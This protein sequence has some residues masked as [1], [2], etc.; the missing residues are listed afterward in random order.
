MSLR[1]RALLAWPLLAAA[2]GSRAASLPAPRSLAEELDRALQRRRPLLVMAS[3][4]G[5]PFCMTVRD[6][7]LAPLRSQTG[8]PIVQLDMGSVQP[9][10]TFDGRATTHAQLLREWKVGIAPSVLFFGRGGREVAERLVGAS[11]PDFYGAYLDQRLATAL[12]SIAG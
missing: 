9:V 7:F 12:K 2:T 4:D 8:Q 5:C 3:L 1:R 11:I 6:N 10:A